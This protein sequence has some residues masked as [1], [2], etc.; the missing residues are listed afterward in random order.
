MR[1]F[2]N[3]MHAAQ[4]LS[5]NLIFLRDEKPIVI[6]IAN[7][8]VPIGDIVA[9]ELGAQ[10][11]VL[12]IEKLYVPEHPGQCV[13]AIDEHGRVCVVHGA[14]RWHNLT[15]ND[16][17]EPA[18]GVFPEV[19]RRHTAIR[20]LLPEIEVRGRT[21]II[22]D[23]G[24]ASGAK[25][26]GAITAIKERGAAKV[27]VAAPAGASQGTWQLH[28]LANQVVI[29]HNPAKFKGIEGFYEDFSDVTD[30]MVHAILE[31]WV[32]DFHPQDH[33]GVKTVVLKLQNSRGNALLCEIDLPAGMQR[34]HRHPAV[35]FAHGF[36]S[37][38]RSSRSM[39][40][41]ERL[42][43]R[44]VVGVRLDFTGHG[45]SGGSIHDAS[46]RQ[47]RDDLRIVMQSVVKLK[48]VDRERL[49][50]IGSGTGAMIALQHAEDDPTLRAL[51]LRGPVCNMAAV[52]ASAV[53]TPTL[54]I[55]AEHDTALH[56]TVATLDRD[57]AAR[58]KL[59]RIDATNRLFNDS[60]G[61]DRMVSAT[62]D[63]L[64]EQLLDET[65]LARDLEHQGEHADQHRSERANGH[66]AQAA[67]A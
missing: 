53:R 67:S 30:A 15:E 9:R 58:H 61:M 11:D 57:L 64:I 56:D 47:M 62:V 12:V 31:G 7:G 51:V 45:R 25:M 8:G 40:I 43:A 27:I 50:I 28:A 2:K 22:V 17:V 19:Q 49:A 55:H 34:G 65:P 42:A 18:Q 26:L 37:S 33:G 36:E 54:L 52:H 44:G 14:T 10:F 1:L 23:E 6:A 66:H 59:V 38:A 13:G 35:V 29:A 5:E 46:D 48:E 3:R 32:R 24:V 20:T 63:W 4:E 21:V 60:A 16:L 39:A 41:S